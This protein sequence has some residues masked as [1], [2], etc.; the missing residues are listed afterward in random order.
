[1]NDIAALVCTVV[2]AFVILLLVYFFVRPAPNVELLSM[3]KGSVS[4]NVFGWRWGEVVDVFDNTGRSE[5]KVSEAVAE[6]DERSGAVV[7]ITTNLSTANVVVHQSG[8]ACGI[9]GAAGCAYLPS[10]TDG[11]AHGQTNIYL[12]AFV[13][14][15]PGTREHVTIHELG[16][17]LG[18]DHAP[19]T[20]K[21]VMRP[22]VGPNNYFTRPQ[23]YDYRDMQRLYGH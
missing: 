5:W 17:T 16:H 21:S 8:S 7:R 6:W 18:L 14:Q 2:A 22:S 19:S 23:S 11:I 4:T 12:A 3:D 9:L 13:L 20:A 10:V 1:M 15:Y